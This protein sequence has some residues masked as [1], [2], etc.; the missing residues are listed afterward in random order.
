MRVRIRV[1]WVINRLHESIF[2]FGVGFALSFQD[3]G[4]C[5]SLNTWNGNSRTPRFFY[6]F[7]DCME[8]T[9]TKNNTIMIRKSEISLLKANLLSLLLAA[10]V[11]GVLIPLFN[12]IHPEKFITNLDNTLFYKGIVHL[13]ELMPDTISTTSSMIIGGMMNFIRSNHHICSGNHENTI[14]GRLIF[15]FLQNN[16]GATG[17]AIL[18]V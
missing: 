10:V 4:Q 3:D 13:V 5:E 16:H 12:W 9:I 11:A 15:F 8:S 1:P 14:L 18:V 2:I 17:S 7:T 6:I